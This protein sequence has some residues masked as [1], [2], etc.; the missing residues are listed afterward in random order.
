MSRRLLR[1]DSYKQGEKEARSAHSKSR[2]KA[3]FGTMR[4][5]YSVYCPSNATSSFVPNPFHFLRVACVEESLALVLGATAACA[6]A[7]IA[8]G[9]RTGILTPGATCC[10]A[11]D[12]AAH[13]APVAAVGGCIGRAVPLGRSFSSIPSALA[14]QFESV[15]GVRS[16]GLSRG[17]RCT[18]CAQIR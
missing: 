13:G 4:S 9:V 1:L 2:K 17:R 16:S 8:M 6:C 18:G 14:T 15:N 10:L 3:D 5:L 12:A 7:G 11:C